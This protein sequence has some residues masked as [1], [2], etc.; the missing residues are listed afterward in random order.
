MTQRRPLIAVNWKMNCLR[1]D[2]LV[3]ASSLAAKAAEKGSLDC[4]VL[5][6]PPA[7]LLSEVVGTTHNSAVAVG[8]QDCHAAT[9]GEHTGDI[10]AAMLADV[11][12]GY[13]LVG[14]SERRAHTGER[15]T[16]I[17]PTALAVADAG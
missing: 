17:T 4:D 5:V 7:T 9:S 13:V 14:P 2:G 8:G 11:G 10:A 1:S 15:L 3:L 12:A 16:V 6:C